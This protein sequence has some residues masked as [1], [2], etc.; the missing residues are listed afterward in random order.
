LIITNDPDLLPLGNYGGPAQTMP[1]RP[2]S[3]VLGAGSVAAN[4]FTNDQ[5]GYPR[6]QNGLVDLGAV[7][8]PIVQPFTAN[9][10]RGLVPLTVRFSSTNADS[11]GSAIVGWAWSFGDGNHTT[12]QNPTNVYGIA[13]PFSPA[14]TV[15]NSLGLRLS[16]PGPAISVYQPLALA[17]PRLSGTNLTLSGSDGVSGL[18]Y[19]VLTSTNVTLPL[20]Q[21]TPLVTNTWNT[22]GPFSLTLTN[23]LNPPLPRQFYLVGT[24]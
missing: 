20:S 11:D 24:P 4:T 14:L 19:T 16:V 9:P 15:Q 1:P 8:L 22:N 3:P 23:A 6:T 7:E 13:G 17:G 12:L 2:G 21:W 10:T 18:A 5:R